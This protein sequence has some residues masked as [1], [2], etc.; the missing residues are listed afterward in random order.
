[1]TAIRSHFLP[2]FIGRIDST[3]IFNKLGMSQVRSIVDIR[4][5]ELQKVRT[6]KNFM[7]A[8]FLC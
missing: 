6:F 3:V 7:P 2:E 4:L 5:K 8:R 1:M